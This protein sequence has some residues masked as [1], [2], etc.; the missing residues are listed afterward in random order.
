MKSTLSDR[1]RF[2]PADCS[3]RNAPSNAGARPRPVAADAA[4]YSARNEA[5]SETEGRQTRLHSQSL[6]PKAPS[7]NASRRSVVPQ[8]QK[9]RTGCEGRISVVKRRHGAQPLPI[10]GRNGMGA[11]GRLGWIADN[12]INIGRAMEKQL[13]SS[14]P[15]TSPKPLQTRRPPRRVCFGASLTT[16][17]KRICAGK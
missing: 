11:L 13:P 4:F 12:L 6:E 2:G 14:R 5:S 1:A 15:L 8:R 7:A 16:V 3:H 10:Q 9:W 17:P